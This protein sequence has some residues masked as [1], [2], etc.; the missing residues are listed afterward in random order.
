MNNEINANAAGKPCVMIIFLLAVKPPKMAA[1]TTNPINRYRLKV[2]IDC[3]RTNIV[4][5]M[6]TPIKP[7]YRPWLAILI[8]VSGVNRYSIDRSNAF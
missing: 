2:A 3:G 7:L 8:L 6:P 5:R 4:N 1:T